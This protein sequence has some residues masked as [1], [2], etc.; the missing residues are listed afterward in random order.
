EFATDR[1]VAVGHLGIVPLEASVS[2]ARYLSALARQARRGLF[3][4]HLLDEQAYWALVGAD[5]DDRKGLLS[6]D[7]AL[8]IDAES[9]SLEPFLWADE[10]LIPWADVAHRGAR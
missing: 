1:P 6:E 8:E 7:G 9:F 5:G 2:P 3:P 4:R 10:Q